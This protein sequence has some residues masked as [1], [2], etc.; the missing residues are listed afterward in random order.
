MKPL[1]G[2]RARPFLAPAKDTPAYPSELAGAISP[3]ATRVPERGEAAYLRQVPDAIEIAH[4]ECVLCVGG[5]DHV[6]SVARPHT[7]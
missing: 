3:D 2:I 4:H 1:A 5:I 6:V 7:E